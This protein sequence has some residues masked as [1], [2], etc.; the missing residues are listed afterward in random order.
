MQFS[1]VASLISDNKNPIHD[2]R[3]LFERHQILI[4]QGAFRTLNYD[5]KKINKQINTR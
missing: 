2:T 4:F 3:L 5:I 1:I